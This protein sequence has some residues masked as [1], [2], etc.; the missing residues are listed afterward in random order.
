[1]KN[2]LQNSFTG[3]RINE[4][5]LRNKLILL[6]VVC[7][8]LPI[9]VTDG[10][11]IYNVYR[12]YKI[13][14][15][16]EVQSDATAVKYDLIDNLE[17]PA[18]IIRNIYKNTYIEDLLNKRYR[19]AVEYY[20]AYTDF[21]RNSLYESW[22][23]NGIETV[24]IY[25]DNDTI[26]NGGMFYR[27]SSVKNKDWYK[28]LGDDDNIV[29][30]FALDNNVTDAY[31]T[32]KVYLLRKIN[33]GKNKNCEKVLK[34]EI[35]YR[36][37]KD[38][39]LND[40]IKS[41]I[42]VCHDD[43]LIMSNVVSAGNTE[44]YPVFDRSTKYDY[45]Y[46]I[47]LY[48]DDYTVYVRSRERSLFDYKGTLIPAIIFLIIINIV[49]PTF[50]IY[51]LDI[52]VARRISRLDN[53]FEYAN[54]ENLKEVEKIQ[55]IEGNDEIT[56]LMINYNKM[57]D[58]LNEMMQT[59]YVN[60][61]KE[62]EMDIARQNAELLALQSQINPHFLF[63]ALESIRMHSLIKKEDETAEMVENL[64]LMQRANVDW[65]A[66]T[67][68]INGE[69]DTVEAYLK[70]QKYRFGDRLKFS[71]DIA[72]E[73]KNMMIPKLSIVTFVENAIIHGIENKAEAGWIF[74]R[75]NP[76]EDGYILEIE[77]TG[78]GMEEEERVKMVEL[79][80]NA[81]LE[82]IK[83]QKSIGVVN[84]CLRLKMMTDNNVSFDVE[85]EPGIGTTIII[86]IKR[87]G[88]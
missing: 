11:V 4:M 43:R 61:I 29:L 87:K 17:Y 78:V 75:A 31:G 15:I 39:V 6:F 67:V 34:M 49:L 76:D 54:N 74:V 86:R 84:A 14:R 7:V 42:Y 77:D 25:A 32:R 64:A 16:Q 2:L 37:F 28:R 10:I 30:M 72:P 47:K 62:Q 60:R 18:A 51:R 69:M 68:A 66:D 41:D 85:S 58:R 20:D 50:M 9:I 81:S 5:K 8:I 56:S 27:L 71:L 3:K 57:A 1:M 12:V 21:K 13:Q 63:N 79:M 82:I 83:S 65:S 88:M 26:L 38:L 40:S 73:C 55:H 35:N 44:D 45:K 53:V 80:N 33:R 59:V 48:G 52:S 36:F 22:F 23:S 24:E 19:N 46:D 70:L